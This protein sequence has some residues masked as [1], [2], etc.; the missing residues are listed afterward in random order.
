M[1]HP[2][3]CQQFRLLLWCN[4]V[5]DI[6]THFRPLRT[7]EHHLNATA[8]LSNVADHAHPYMATV[9]RHPLLQTIVPRYKAQITS[10]CFLEHDNQVTVLKRPPQPQMCYVGL[11]CGAAGDLLHGCVTNL[12]QLRNAVMSIWTENC[13]QHRVE[14]IHKELGQFLRQ[15][16]IQPSNN[17]GNLIKWLVSVVLNFWLS[18]IWQVLVKHF[19]LALWK[20]LIVCWFTVKS[21]RLSRWR[22]PFYKIDQTNWTLVLFIL[23]YHLICLTCKCVILT[24]AHTCYWTGIAQ[25]KSQPAFVW[26]ASTKKMLMIFTASILIQ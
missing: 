5:R 17:N 11:R 15:K 4:G 26:D 18:S 6:L 25:A 10:N 8:Y 7:L 19:I 14:S 21:K 3:W 1:L 16:G 12:Q 13:L 24:T 2:A 9:Y 20:P 23:Y 22:C